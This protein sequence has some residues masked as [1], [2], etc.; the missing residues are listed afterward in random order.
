MTI[1]GINPR[2]H[3]AEGFA[4][5]NMY[6]RAGIGVGSNAGFSAFA[7]LRPRT[8]ALG[9]GNPSEAISFGCLDSSEGTTG[10]GIGRNVGSNPDRWIRYAMALYGGGGSGFADSL[11]SN[12]LQR[13]FL[14]GFTFVDGAVRF[15]INGA[16]VIDEL[17]ATF[18][19]GATLCLGG[20]P[21]GF[22]NGVATSDGIIGAGF[23]NTPW[24]FDQWEGVWQTLKSTGTLT[25]PNMPSLELLYETRNLV[26]ASGTVSAPDTWANQGTLGAAGDLNRVAGPADLV[27]SDENNPAY[28]SVSAT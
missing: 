7:A 17:P 1:A 25:G 4:T 26:V 8:M 24:S 15:Y 28:G 11:G 27:F 20:D 23:V 21:T 3:I 14:V 9:E 19:I 13:I 10:W 2:S 18:S 12:C 16:I 6:S 5:G 22:L